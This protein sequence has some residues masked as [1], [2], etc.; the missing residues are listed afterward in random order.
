MR[1]YLLAV[2]SAIK[3]RGYVVTAS[4]PSKTAPHFKIGDTFTELWGNK[5]PFTLKITE[6]TDL[7]DWEWQFKIACDRGNTKQP[8]IPKGTRFWRAVKDTDAIH[9]IL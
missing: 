2:R 7:H 6:E 5:I 1:D 9:D 3:E 4:V 8:A